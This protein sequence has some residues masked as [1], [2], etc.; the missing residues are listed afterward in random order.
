MQ[1]IIL[2]PVQPVQFGLARQRVKMDV[3]VVNAVNGAQAIFFQYG[4]AGAG[5]AAASSLSAGGL[6][7]SASSTENHSPGAIA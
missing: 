3:T 5:H 2:V 6:A 7:H 4:G 1:L